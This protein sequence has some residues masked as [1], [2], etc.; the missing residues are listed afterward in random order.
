M[1]LAVIAL[2]KGGAELA[3]WLAAGWDGPVDIFLGG[4]AGRQKGVA[5]TT[6][7]CPLSELVGHLLPQYRA[8]VMIMALGI[9]V[10]T[11]GPLLRDK[12]QDPA[13]VCLDEG[14]NFAI[15]VASGHMGG[16]N[17]LAQKLARLTG[18]VPVITTATD[19]KDRPAFDLMAL[20]HNLAI[21]PFERIKTFNAALVNGELIEIF[22]EL[23]PSD[24]G[25]GPDTPRWESVEFRPWRDWNQWADWAL[26]H[27]T[28]AAKYVV[29]VTNLAAVDSPFTKDTEPEI[30]YLRPRSLIAGIGCRRGISAETVLEALQLACAQAGVSPLSIKKLA[31]VDLKRDEQGLL[32]AAERLGLLVDFFDREKIDA[33]LRAHPELIRSD[34]VK[35][36][37][38]VEGVCEPAA[39]LAGYQPVL[40]LPKTG[41][42]G[43][44]V[45][46]AQ[47]N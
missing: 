26:H 45:A 37:I 5:V 31:S 2:T 16:A 34:Y 44:T 17:R 15:S 41:H 40:I 43:V 35:A 46:L 3:G 25:Y 36:Q 29:L 42:R 6:F 10:R 22:S 23:S 13:I 30:L 39:L 24:L 38:G 11:V 47:E 19:V 20:D 9:V 18:A 4:Q 32:E 27:Q 8:I 33:C 1:K 12:R 21:E 28:E 14:V 7:V